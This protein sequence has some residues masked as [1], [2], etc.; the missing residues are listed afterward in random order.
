MRHTP[1]I[2]QR[3]PASLSDYEPQ[4]KKRSAEPLRD[5]WNAEQSVRAIWVGQTGQI[6]VQLLCLMFFGCFRDYLPDREYPDRNSLLAAI[7]TWGAFNGPLLTP[8]ILIPVAIGRI[9]ATWETDGEWCA[10]GKTLLLVGV[11][12]F[13]A[14]L[15]FVQCVNAAD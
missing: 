3:S 14:F 5:L 1:T 13:L 4:T 15:A 7:Y 11:S 10:L 8:L 9:R 12:G 2:P 6:F